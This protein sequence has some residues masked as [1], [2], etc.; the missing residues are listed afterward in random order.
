MGF[1]VIIFYLEQ[2][3]K[4][5]SSTLPDLDKS[6]ALYHHLN[7]EIINNEE[8]ELP[9]LRNLITFAFENRIFAIEQ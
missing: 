4:E 5:L 3:G 9:G 1:K 7:I 8:F 2:L 6:R